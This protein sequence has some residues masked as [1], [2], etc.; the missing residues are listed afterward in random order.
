VH[1]SYK[2]LTD[3]PKRFARRGKAFLDRIDFSAGEAMDRAMIIAADPPRAAQ[4]LFAG[5][6][7]AEVGLKIAEERKYQRVLSGRATA[8]C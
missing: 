4:K 6:S 8:G 1:H 2:D 5:V 7:P 3:L